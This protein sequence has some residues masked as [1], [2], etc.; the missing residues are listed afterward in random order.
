MY[1]MLTSLLF[2][3]AADTT[4]VLESSYSRQ[5]FEL[6]ADPNSEF[7]TAASPV[8]ADRNYLGQPIPGAPTRIL[9]RWSSQYLYLLFICPYDELNLKP[10]LF[11]G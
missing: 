11:L 6:S 7:W 5:D 2:L 8:T 10:R 3:A 9:S 1:W 4:A